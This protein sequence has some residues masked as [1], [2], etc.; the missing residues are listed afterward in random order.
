MLGK[1]NAT[2]PANRWAAL[3]TKSL[4]IEKTQSLF[5]CQFKYEASMSLSQSVRQDLRW[6]LE[7]LADSSAPVRCPK[8]D[9]V[10]HTD[11][12]SEGWGCYDPQSGKKGRQMDRTGD[13]VSYQLFGNKSDFLGAVESGSRFPWQTYQNYD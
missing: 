3:F 8:P 7:N 4:E 10:I 12:S 5:D 9:Y 2:R 6:V 13:P 1:I 11:A